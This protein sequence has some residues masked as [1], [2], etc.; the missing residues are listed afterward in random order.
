M[1]QS[2][3]AVAMIT[4]PPSVLSPSFCKR[5]QH[6]VDTLLSIRAIPGYYSTYT[7]IYSPTVSVIIFGS[8][9]ETLLNQMRTEMTKLTS[10]QD[11]VGLL[12]VVHKV[13]QINTQDDYVAPRPMTMNMRRR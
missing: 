12:H 10:Y 11:M 7:F 3:N 6:L 13:A 2:T 9:W 4:F 1:I 5:C 8:V